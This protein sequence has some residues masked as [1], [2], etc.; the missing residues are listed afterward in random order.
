MDPGFFGTNAD[1]SEN[2]E[3]CRFCWEKGIFVEPELT[4]A[5][6]IEKTASHLV[7]VM[8][9]SET[10][11]AELANQLIPPLKRWQ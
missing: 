6:M 1:G 2:R 3:Y 8:Q 7:R 5:G 9:Y 4:R 10:K 11:A